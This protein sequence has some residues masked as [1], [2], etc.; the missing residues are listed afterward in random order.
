MTASGAGRRHVPFRYM[1]KYDDGNS[2]PRA[3]R[4]ER[5][6]PARITPGHRSQSSAH[7]GARKTLPAAAVWMVLATLLLVAVGL[8]LWLA[9]Q[10]AAPPPVATTP[11]PEPLPSA[12]DAP[13]P[14]ADALLARREKAQTLSQM[15]AD[16]HQR[17]AN[18]GV[19]RW[20]R[21]RYAEIHMLARRGENRFNARD[22]VGAAKTYQSALTMADKVLGQADTVLA[23]ALE[24]GRQA[25]AHGDAAVAVAAF[26]LALAVDAD[27]A[28]A[29]RGAERAASLDEVS[30][31]LR[32]GR[33]REQDEELMSARDAYRRALELDGESEPARTALKRVDSALVQRRF[34]RHMS[35]GLAALERG[36]YTS[37][38]VAFR[39]A[40]QIQPDTAEVADGLAQAEAGLQGQAIVELRTHT[41]GLVADEQWRAALAE[42]EKLLAIDD[43]LV[44]AQAGREQAA[45]RALLAER[46]AYHIHHPRRLG[47]HNVQASAAALLAEAR[48]IP[49]PGPELRRQILSLADRLAI[50]RTPVPV[51]LR[52]DNQTEVLLYHVGNLGA[53]ESKAMRLPPGQYTAVGRRLGYRDVRREFTVAVGQPGGPIVIRCQER[54]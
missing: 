24:R 46:L 8:F 36:N 52:S 27:D 5:I 2:E 21:Q 10:V 30:A 41:E 32:Q 11:V 6:T 50:A 31:L 14:D 17:L 48:T 54:I 23:E 43:T 29:K 15:L 4:F 33:S 3:Q 49:R 35:E 18:R 9:Q 42:Y 25:L 47:S 34:L 38:R 12:A 20:G 26:D 16:K 44:F 22:Y 53:F 51:R 13:A 45:A 39:A 19:E 37:A 1:A 7:Q 28:V 40:D